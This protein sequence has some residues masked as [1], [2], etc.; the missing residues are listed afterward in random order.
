MPER[1]TEEE[2]VALVRAY[3]VERFADDDWLCD[4]CETWVRRANG[5]AHDCPRIRFESLYPQS[6][7]TDK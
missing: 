6:K 5:H 2:L 1:M 4:A 3:P 7:E